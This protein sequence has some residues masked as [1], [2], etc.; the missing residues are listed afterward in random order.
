MSAS[1]VPQLGFRVF[2]KNALRF[3]E[4]YWWRRDR[5]DQIFWDG[6]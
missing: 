3:V 4:I 1:T 6:S 2:H 5:R